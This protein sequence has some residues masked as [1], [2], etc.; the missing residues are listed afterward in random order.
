VSSVY[1]TK[2]L[3]HIASLIDK[4][5]EA[6]GT[7]A[8]HGGKYFASPVEIRDNDVSFGFVVSQDGIWGFRPHPEGPRDVS[9]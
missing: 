1:G 5:E 7:D 9:G 3:Q 4:L 8:A 6:E 2:D